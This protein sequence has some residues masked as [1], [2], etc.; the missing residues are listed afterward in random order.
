MGLLV[1]PLAWLAALAGAAEGG[2]G[3]DAADAVGGGDGSG[4]AWVLG[5]FIA[6]SASSPGVEFAEG[7]NCFGHLWWWLRGF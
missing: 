4:G 6:C 2:V 5:D 3:A 7:Q 1:L